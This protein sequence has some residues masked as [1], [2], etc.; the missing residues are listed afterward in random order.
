MTT[1]RCGEGGRHTVVGEHPI[2]PL[3]GDL[4][5]QCTSQRIDAARMSVSSLASERWKPSLDYTR[6]VR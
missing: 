2:L 6:M 4:V 5:F 3:S 1:D